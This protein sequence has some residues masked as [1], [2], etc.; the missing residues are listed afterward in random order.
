MI[1]KDWEKSFL[2]QADGIFQDCKAFASIVFAY[3]KKPPHET[4][5]R[6]P[7]PTP[8]GGADESTT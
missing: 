7:L 1:V 8:S 2:G 4:T 3:G 5:P 6:G